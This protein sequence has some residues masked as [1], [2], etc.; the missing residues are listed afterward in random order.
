MRYAT[1]ALLCVAQYVVVLDV[2]IVAVALPSI[3]RALEFADA[4]LQWVIVAYTICFAAL[5]TVAGRAADLRGRRRVF[6]LGLALFGAAS[7]ACGLAPSAAT[8]VAARAGQGIG[9]AALSAAALALLTAT[10]SADRQRERAVAAWTAAAAGGGASGWVLG[11]LVTQAL[12]WRWVF[13]ANVPLAIAALAAVPR[14]LPPD[15]SHP[16]RR[17]RWTVAARRRRHG[18]SRVAGPWPRN[19]SGRRDAPAPSATLDLPGAATMASGLAALVLALASIERH[20][21]LSPLV[22]GAL[23][24]AV[25]LLTAFVA[26]ERRVRDPLVPAATLR[27]PGFAAAMGAAIVLTATTTPAMFLAMLLQQRVLDYSPAEAGLGSAPFNVA[28]IVG[29]AAGP[30]LARLAGPVRAIACGMLAIAA[31]AGVLAGAGAETAYVHVLAALALMGAGLGCASVASTTL[32]TA[33][34]AGRDQGLASG[35]LGTAAQVGTVLGLAIVV[36]LAAAAARAEGLADGYSIGQLAVFLAAGG[37]ATTFL[38]RRPRSS[39][40]G[41]TRATQDSPACANTGRA[42]DA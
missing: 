33:A 34:L 40:P 26:N 32:G 37:A 24:G 25:V 10:F 18:S 39:A 29:S 13:F 17:P 6:V 7:L 36:P 21:A 8:L 27:R 30:A 28:V 42:G 1:L 4:S 2:T 12:D 15:A 3:Q 16:P 31:G 14:L 22:L 9:A 20:G 19:G 38:L 5:L 35:L 11:G 23:G 41:M